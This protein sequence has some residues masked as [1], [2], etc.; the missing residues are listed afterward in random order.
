MG[1]VHLCRR[2]GVEMP[3]I[4]RKLSRDRLCGHCLPMLRYE[5]ESRLVRYVVEKLGFRV[6]YRRR[7]LCL[8]CGLGLSVVA[9]GDRCGRCAAKVW[10]V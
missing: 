1:I 7:R 10:A 4:V 6:D 3:L 2:C 9:V 8:D 5:N